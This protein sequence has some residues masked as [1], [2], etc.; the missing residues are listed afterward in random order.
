MRISEKG[1]T[2]T[3]SDEELHI[4]HLIEQVLFTAQGERVNRPTFGCGINQLVFATNSDVIATATQVLVQGSLHQWLGDIIRTE[5]VEIKNEDA[6]LVITVRY[7]II[8]N[9]KPQ[10]SS[11]TRSA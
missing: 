9:N 11:F 1:S 10:I 5:S 4:R 6:I 8:R 2:Q 7:V 3:I